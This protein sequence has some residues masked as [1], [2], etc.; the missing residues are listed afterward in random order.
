MDRFKRCCRENWIALLVSIVSLALAGLFVGGVIEIFDDGK[1]DT[2]KVIYLYQTYLGG[3]FALFAAI[4]TVV[5]VYAA[6]TL[7]LKEERRKK[8]EGDRRKELTGVIVML[9]EIRKLHDE[10]SAIVRKSARSFAETDLRSISIEGIVMPQWFDNL[11]LISA[12]RETVL[13]EMAA[14]YVALSEFQVA[15][16]RPINDQREFS[17]LVETTQKAAKAA[18]ALLDELG[19]VLSEIS[20]LSNA[21]INDLRTK[22]DLTNK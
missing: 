20:D 3:G 1:S 4:F 18:H 11:E 22:V 5:G 7:P 10:L 14:L 19:A 15:T 21:E 2:S 17:D 6:A 9:I 16:D 13:R 8:K 12:Q